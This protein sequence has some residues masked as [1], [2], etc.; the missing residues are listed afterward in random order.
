[1]STTIN[2]FHSSFNPPPVP[3]RQGHRGGPALPSNTPLVKFISVLLLLLMILMFGG[4]IYLFHRISTLQDRRSD[5]EISALKQL[6][7]C[8]ENNLASEDLQ[9]CSHLM[10]LYKSVLK[11]VSEAEGRAALLTETGSFTIPQ[12]RLVL[13]EPEEKDHSNTL[14]WSKSLSMLEKI[15]L[16]ISG[17]LTIQYPGYYLIQS[18]VAFSKAHEKASLYQ[19]IW[20]QKAKGEMANQLLQSYCSLPR[21]SAIPDLCTA[22]QTGVFRLE[23][24]QTLFVNVTDKSLVNR[25]STTFGLFRLQD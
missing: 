25:R 21:G 12:A 7:Q 19:A 5:N 9:Y 18:Q 11:R 10:G 20:T 3:P 14:V 2:T 15:T 16:S 24:G 8:G 4:F 17:V 23:K 13:S 6:Q 22:S 1:M